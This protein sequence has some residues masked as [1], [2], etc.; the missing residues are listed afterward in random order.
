MLTVVDF[1]WDELL[2]A[3]DKIYPAG[4]MMSGREGC[5]R[6]VL[7]KGRTT[8]SAS[9][10]LNVVYVIE[11]CAEELTGDGESHQ[12][13]QQDQLQFVRHRGQDKGTRC[14][15]GS[16][17]RIKTVLICALILVVLSVG[18]SCVTS[19][20]SCA[21]MRIGPRSLQLSPECAIRRLLG[22]VDP[23]ATVLPCY[24]FGHLQEEC[25]V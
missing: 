11:L 12:G 7:R 25:S 4:R 23:A 19:D 10:V 20:R 22:S 9:V 1:V 18:C 14:K 13:C 15:Y 21:G 5:K 6:R 24:R 17:G 8:Q 2:D 3:C 16:D